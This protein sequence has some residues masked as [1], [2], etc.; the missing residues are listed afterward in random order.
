M[1]K[2]VNIFQHMTFNPALPVIRIVDDE[3]PGKYQVFKTVCIIRCDL[4]ESVILQEDEV[5]QQRA[6]E[7]SIVLAVTLLIER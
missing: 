3:K 4:K 7:P 6:C 5:A 2:H 1:V